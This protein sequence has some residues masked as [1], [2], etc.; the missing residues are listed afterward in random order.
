VQFPVDSKAAVKHLTQHTTAR[1]TFV[2]LRF[3]GQQRGAGTPQP[4]VI[5]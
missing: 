5:G 1:T 3:T 4:D 2:E